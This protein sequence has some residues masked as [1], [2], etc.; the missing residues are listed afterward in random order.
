MRVRL[1]VSSAFVLL[2]AACGGVADLVEDQMTAVTEGDTGD[3]GSVGGSSDPVDEGDP[4]A[5]RLSSGTWENA[6]T[7]VDTDQVAAATGFTVLE[8][9][10]AQGCNWVIEQ[11]D[12]DVI[13]ESVLGWQPMAARNVD[14]QYE[15]AGMMGSA[16]AL[17][18]IDGLGTMA[19]WQGSGIGDLG[20]VWVQTDQIGFRVTN[21]FAGPNYS[22]DPRAPLEALA[23]E[24]VAALGTL[25]VIAASGDD[26]RMALVP[27]TS[28]DIPDGLTVLDGLIDEL[29]AVPMPDSGVEYGFGDVYPDRASQDVYSE[30]GVG[31][32]V[33]FFLEAL[34]A[35][36]FEIRDNSMVRTEADVLEYASQAISFLDPEGRTGDIGIR[37][38]MFAPS[39]WNI[40]IFLP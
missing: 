18:P 30:L 3:S 22:G 17:E 12:S 20:E 25:D 36:G 24:L 23:A 13:G 11:V 40:Q 34:P 33:R 35:A 29:A 39:Q 37:Q 4:S 2:V 1:V 9:R 27:P 38:G 6:C 7:V 32:A 8:A 21:Q 26:A 31:D 10:E 14:V 28:I 16:V 19:F 15:S 5:F